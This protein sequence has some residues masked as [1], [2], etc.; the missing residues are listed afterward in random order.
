M[1]FKISYQDG[2]N[3]TD[4]NGIIEER[5]TL[6]DLSAPGRPIPRFLAP[7]ATTDVWENETFKVLETIYDG[8]YIQFAAKEEQIIEI[9]KIKACDIIKIKDLLHD[10]EATCDNSTGESFIINEPEKVAGTTN[11]RVTILYRSDKK[12]VNKIN[13]RSNVVTIIG[14]GTYYSKFKKLTLPQE[15][16]NID[17]EW[18]DGSTKRLREKTK[19]GYRVLLYLN[20]TDLD[21]FLKD[22]GQN[23]FTIDGTDV[24][25]KLP[26]QVSEI[27]EGL[28]RVEVQVITN[29]DQRTT[30]SVTRSS[31][32][33]V[34]NIDTTNNYYTDYP[35]NAGYQDTDTD[36]LTGQ[37]DVLIISK[38]VTRQVSIVKLYMSNAE[39]ADFKPKFETSKDI[40]L[41][42]VEVKENRT[43]QSTELDN[44][45]N[46]VTVE[47]LITPNTLFPQQTP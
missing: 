32:T 20:N 33:H 28:N 38:A 26:L 36:T 1:S 3:W 14:S 12:L 2:E 17:V 21:T 39:L 18:S 29:V 22:Y 30:L 10:E 31:Q 4:L 40:L 45:I 5:Q 44:D 25:E 23:D 15:N 41:D 46:E 11:L 43:V 7:I 24:I 27:A 13:S 19:S 9:S 34:I 35:V 42:T 16:V 8:R 6:R 37:D 47:C